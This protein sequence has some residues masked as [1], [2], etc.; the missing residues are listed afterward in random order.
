MLKTKIMGAC[1]VFDAKWSWDRNY[2]RAIWI[3]Y[4][5]TSPRIF[6]QVEIEGY[7]VC[8]FTRNVSPAWITYKLF[9]ISPA[10][11]V[12]NVSGGIPGYMKHYF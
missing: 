8:S 4:M 10:S 7:H 1:S 6:K 5:D 3:S 11:N 12:S 9:R 2:F